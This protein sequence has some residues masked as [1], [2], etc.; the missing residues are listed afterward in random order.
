MIKLLEIAVAAID[1]AIMMD[2]SPTAH[3]SFTA[4][5]MTVS[6]VMFESMDMAAFMV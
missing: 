1:Y 2:H 3:C 5:M 4:G 6:G